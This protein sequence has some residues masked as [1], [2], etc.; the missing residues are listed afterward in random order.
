MLH[1]WE[2]K[3]VVTNARY[4]EAPNEYAR[5]SLFLAGGITGTQDWQSIVVPRISDLHI[6]IF[7]PRRHTFDIAKKEE[8]IKQI[9]WEYRHLRLCDECLFYFPESSVCPITLFE[10]G[11]QLMMAGKV[12]FIGMHPDYS[13][14]LDIETQTSIIRPDIRIAHGLEQLIQQVR[15]YYE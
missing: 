8:S 9:R 6:T 14:R 12:I 13:R 2:D 5:R 3:Q 4:V 7:N 1:P 11:A 10:L 15:A